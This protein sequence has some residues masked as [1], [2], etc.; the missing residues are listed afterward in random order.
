MHIRRHNKCNRGGYNCSLSLRVKKYC[1]TEEKIESSLYTRKRNSVL[2]KSCRK[3]K[4]QYMSTRNKNCV[5]II[6]RNVLKNLPLGSQTDII[7]LPINLSTM[8][9]YRLIKVFFSETKIL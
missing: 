6:M 3:N 1:E 7:Y 2:N 9:V 8:N 5:V 4:K